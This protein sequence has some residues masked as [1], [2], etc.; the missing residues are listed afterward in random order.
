MKTFKLKML[1]VLKDDDVEEIQLIDGLI[2]NR[3]DESYE[4]QWLIEAYVDKEYASYFEKIKTKKFVRLMVK[5]SKEDNVPVEFTATI[6]GIN[7]IGTNINVLFKGDINRE[8]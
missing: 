5:I 8:K 2:I 6:I 1:Q 7:Q 4:N 3:E